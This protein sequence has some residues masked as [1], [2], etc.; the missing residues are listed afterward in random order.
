MN[1]ETG[2]VTEVEA[3]LAHLTEL[4]SSLLT[5]ETAATMASASPEIGKLAAA[6][7]KAQADMS[8]A[9]K[10]SRNPHFKSFF[11]DLASV[12]EA[13]M[14]SLSKNAIALIQRVNGREVQTILAHSSGEWMA[15]STPIIV[16][17]GCNPQQYG[18][19][20]TYARRYSL[21]AMVGLAP[22]DD[23]GEA[24]TG[25]YRNQNQNR[26]SAPRNTRRA[27]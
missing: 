8:G 14:P 16:Q 5:S 25:P 12:R 7:A 15:S 3:K 13:C 21:M 27:S 6:L 10:N 19:A 1:E 24:A 4:V 22:E 2:E 17:K 9:K 26:G 20:V 11:A 18:S 23:D